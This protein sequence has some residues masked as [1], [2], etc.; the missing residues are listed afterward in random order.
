MSFYSTFDRTP[1]CSNLSLINKC[2]QSYFRILDALMFSFHIPN[3]DHFRRWLSAFLF[4][5]TWIMKISGFKTAD[6][7]PCMPLH[8]FWMSNS[9]NR[10]EINLIWL[11]A[12]IS[13]KHNQFVTSWQQWL[14]RS[15]K[16]CGLD[17][18]HTYL[19]NWAW[20]DLNQ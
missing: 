4:Q 10:G 19:L 18:P 17:L 14:F 7:L 20:S 15:S 5:I 16:K 2:L 8:N 12:Q 13:S 6:S 11:K 1:V 9:V 3:N